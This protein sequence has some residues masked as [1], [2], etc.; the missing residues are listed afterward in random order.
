MQVLLSQGHGS[1]VEYKNDAFWAGTALGNQVEDDITKSYTSGQI[2]YGGVLTPISG[3][4]TSTFLAPYTGSYT[5]SVYTDEGMDLYFHGS[6]IVDKLST[7]GYYGTTT[8]TLSLVQ[9]SYYP[10]LAI[11]G[12]NAGAGGHRFSWAYSGVSTTFIPT[13]NQFNAK[14]AGSSPYTFTIR[15]SI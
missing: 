13:S 15:D 10:I 2:V 1:Y 9:G 12:N 7:G 6:K 8:Y 5:L 11:W 4:I 3:R 14:L